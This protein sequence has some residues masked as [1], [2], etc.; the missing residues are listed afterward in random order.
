MTRIPSNVMHYKGYSARI[1]YDDI[2]QIFVGRLN[3]VQDI[4]VFHGISVEDLQT[5]LQQSVEDYLAAC[6]KLGKKPQKSGS[7]RL[8]I[9]IPPELHSASLHAAQAAGISL[10]QWVTNALQQAAH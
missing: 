2:D 6:E 10:N 7:G 4:V 8:M 5:A 1:E 9:R 3:G